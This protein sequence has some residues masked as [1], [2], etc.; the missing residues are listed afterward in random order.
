MLITG[1]RE[2]DCAYRFGNEW[3]EQRLAGEREP[4]LRLNVPRQRV[5]IAWANGGEEADLVRSLAV[6]R[7]ALVQK[8][9]AAP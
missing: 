6:F 5:Q 4:H 7:A 2:G 9:V 3:T 8:A 1:C